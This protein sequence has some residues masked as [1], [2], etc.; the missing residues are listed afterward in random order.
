MQDGNE[1]FGFELTIADPGVRRRYPESLIAV[2][3]F[4][5]HWSLPA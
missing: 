2:V 3:E 5:D 1:G 4:P